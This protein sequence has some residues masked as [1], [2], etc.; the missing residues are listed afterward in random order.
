MKKYFLLLMASACISVADAQLIK[1][2]EEQKKQADLDWYN[3]SFDKDGVY[4]AEVNKA[5][6]FLKGKK[7]KKRP[8]VA[9]IGSGMD[10]EHEDL[11][12]AIWVNPKEKAD[13]KDNDKNGLVDD[14][15]GWNF[16]GGKD[17]Q[18][19]EA[20]MRE[21]D[22]EFLRLKDKYADYIFD[23]KNY[24][25]VIDGKLTKVAD[26]ENIE[27]Y[28][29]YRNQVL[30]ESPMAGT[31][32]G[33]QLTY[34]LKAYAD[35]FDQMMKERFPGKELTEADFSICYDP[36]AP[37]DSL[38]EVSFMMCAM[39]FGVYKT[40]K[41][42]TVY[43]GIKS[44][45]QIEQAKAEYER[46]VGQFGADGRKDIIGDN[47]LDINDNKYGNNVLLTADAAIGTMEA[48][49]IVA[50]RENGLGGNGIMDQAE[51]MTLRV[52]ANG[53]P[54]LKDIALAIRYAVDHQ[55]DIIMLP[56]QNTL[57]PEDQKKWISEALEY[58]ESKGVFCVTPAWEGAQ[59]LAVETYYPNRWMTGKKELT[60]LMVVCSSDKNGNPSMN[61]N[62]G[63]KEVDLYA[64]GMEIYST[65]TGDTYQSGTGLGLAAATTVGVAALIKAYYPHLTGTQIR[66]ILLETVTSR[67]DAEVE[68]GII[69]DGKPTQDLFLFGDLCL[70]GGIINAYQAVVAADKIAK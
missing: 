37:R 54:Y 14:I 31:Y 3:C 48:G 22:R 47:Y 64:P 7:I 45:A 62:Y 50:K 39:G 18:V 23:G 33:W 6:D 13:G 44:G 38:S 30:P 1:Q 58:A 11:K 56:V 42:E 70:S 5:Y 52:A 46:K 57:Y 4:G 61:S 60:N 19:M 51:I 29:Y 20:T 24:N 49:I 65:Y 16:L 69:V 36:K 12:Q 28:N 68:K 43:A 32:S 8:V 66:N 25:K 9:L 59:D 27:E 53:E 55:A 26:P 21:G 35:K 63:A 10:I 15:N 34:V 17:G 2:N 41:W 67:K 40:D